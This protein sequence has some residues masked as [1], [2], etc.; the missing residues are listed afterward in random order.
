MILSCCIT[1]FCR[2]SVNWKFEE[3]KRCKHF[4]TL[5]PHIIDRYSSLSPQTM[6]G[7]GVWRVRCE[8]NLLVWLAVVLPIWELSLAVG[9]KICIWKKR[10]I[11]EAA[12]A[13]AIACSRMWHICS[14][15]KKERKTSSRL[16]K[17]RRGL[18]REIREEGERGG[19]LWKRIDR[20]EKGKIASPF[21]NLMALHAWERTKWF[22][23]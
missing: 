9:G 18:Y 15:G 8:K 19:C 16:F 2:L 14:G 7:W 23:R 22:E 21:M 13:A 12:A 11:G 10:I 17:H 5:L 1:F 3:I 20:R 6:D 4:E